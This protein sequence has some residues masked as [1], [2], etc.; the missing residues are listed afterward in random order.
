MSE[1]KIISP[2]D[3]ILWG[4]KI[5]NKEGTLSQSIT[6]LVSVTPLKSVE[7]EQILENLMIS[8]I[9]PKLKA[10]QLNRVKYSRLAEDEVVKKDDT[11]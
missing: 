8:Q 9:E 11:D 2:E 1:E 4:R 5:I 10:A 3:A 7:R 6:N